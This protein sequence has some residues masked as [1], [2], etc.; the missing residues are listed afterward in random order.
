[1][2]FLRRVV[3]GGASRSYG[4]QVARLAGLPESLLDRARELLRNLEGGE[5]DERGRP[6][7][8]GGAPAHDDQLG[9]FARGAPR[10]D[11]APSEVLDELRA[12]DTDRTTPIEALE[13]LARLRR[14]LAEEPP[15]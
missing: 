11:A 3:P 7:I 14:R 2:I 5:L 10:P 6:R 15:R 9:L 8:A 4:I 12:V 1:M 13:L